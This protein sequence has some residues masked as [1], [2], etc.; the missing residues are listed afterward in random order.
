M[1]LSRSQL[2]RF[3]SPE[4]FLVV[5][6]FISAAGNFLVLILIGALAGVEELGVYSML[7][8]LYSTAFY[9]FNCGSWRIA[10]KL[11][12]HNGQLSKLAPYVYRQVLTLNFIGCIFSSFLLIL[13]GVFF[14]SYLDIGL[15]YYHSFLACSVVVLFMNIDAPLAYFRM[16]KDYFFLG[17]VRGGLPFIRLFSIFLCWLLSSSSA[18]YVFAVLVADVFFYSIVFLFYFFRASN[19]YFGF[20]RMT[21]HF[22]QEVKGLYW[23][24]FIDLPVLHSDRLIVFYLLGASDTAVYTIL[25]RLSQL[26]SRIGGPIYQLQIGSYSKI[27]SLRVEEVLIRVRKQAFHLASAGFGVCV[28]ISLSSFLVPDL[29]GI[30]SIDF[31]CLTTFLASSLVT[32][33]MIP[34]HSYFFV[35]YSMR[36]NFKALLISNTSF[37]AFLFVVVPY[38]GVLGVGLAL[39]FQSFM[40]GFIKIIYMKVLR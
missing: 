6:E 20:S 22:I 7:L 40:A 9:L 19:E 21:P 26:V 14:Y 5:V 18:E 28:C 13:F 16:S 15:E 31:Y 23:A 38:F 11:S 32:L 25:R 2:N 36:E 3:F 1:K 33:F 37:M 30:G 4:F 29:Y 24:N 10:L 39:V 17:F 27:I 8:S 35:K 34:Y 12:Y